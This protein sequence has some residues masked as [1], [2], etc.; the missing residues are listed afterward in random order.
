MVL[1][2]NLLFHIRLLQDPDRHMKRKCKLALSLT[3]G[4]VKCLDKVLGLLIFVI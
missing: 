3:Q 4:N 2:H 1:Y